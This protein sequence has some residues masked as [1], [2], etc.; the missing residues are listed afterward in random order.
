M[1]NYSKLIAT[2]V[3]TLMALLVQQF[4]LPAEWATQ[5]GAMVVGITGILNSLLVFLFPANEKPSA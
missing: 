4:A 3:A 1:S 2:V 5:E